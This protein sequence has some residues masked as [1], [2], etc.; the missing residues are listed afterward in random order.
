MFVANRLIVYASLSPICCIAYCLINKARLGRNSCVKD[1]LFFKKREFSFREWI[2]MIS[3]R[4]YVDS[5]ECYYGHNAQYSKTPSL[6]L[7]VI[8]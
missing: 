5:D 7:F 1:R 3:D 6:T 4:R 2:L 8:H